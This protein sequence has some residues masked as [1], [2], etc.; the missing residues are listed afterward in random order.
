MFKSK[1][2]SYLNFLKGKTILITTHELADLD[3]VSSSI[4][5]NFFLKK[6]V[7]DLKTILY[8]SGISK[9]T[10]L[11]LERIKQKFPNFNP[12]FAN[13]F[14][15]EDI[16]MFFI[17]DTNK[18]E[19]VDEFLNL[20]QLQRERCHFFFIDHHFSDKMGIIS[21][22]NIEGIFLD[23]YSSTCEIIVDLFEEFKVSYTD[24][25]RFL[26][27][28]GIITD[29]GYFKFANNHTI[30]SIGELLYDNIDYQELRLMLK[31]EP[32]ISEKIARIKGTQRA[33]MIKFN[34]W[35][36][37]ISHVS[38]FE[39][40]VAN[41][42]MKVGFDVAIVFSEREKEHRV[43]IRAK[44]KVCRETGI[45][46]GKLLESISKKFKANGG[47]H[48]GAA[49]INIAKEEGTLKDVIL[50]KIKEKLSKQ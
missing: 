10:E 20:T 7:N 47:G 4:A 27:I 21:K 37:G 9:R 25:I 24:P 2:Q 34:E 46:L 14:E 28:A 8:F 40:S 12:I 31:T 38:S 48:D 49:S 39:A 6:L 26:L 50:D 23:E 41:V 29:S 44:K 15:N 5:L 45:H 22:E 17:L 19:N 3:G 13:S 42:L 30:Q 36:I 18:L 1:I 11:F 35:L 32:D 43:S 16:D 33:E